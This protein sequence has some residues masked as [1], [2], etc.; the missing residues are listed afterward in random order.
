MVADTPVRVGYARCRMPSKARVSGLRIGMRTPYVPIREHQ[1]GSREVIS[2]NINCFIKG[3]RPVPAPGVGRN[4]V[5]CRN[6]CET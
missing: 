4:R 6:F 3:L 2:L 5:L 1:T